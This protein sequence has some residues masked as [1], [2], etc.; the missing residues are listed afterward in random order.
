MSSLNNDDIV[1]GS[2]GKGQM[3]KYSTGKSFKVLSD[4][5]SSSVYSAY[6]SKDGQYFATT[7]SD[8]TAIV[9]DKDGIKL[10]VLRGHTDS[11]F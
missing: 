8:R 2:D 1:F 4:H 5:T 7:S 9:Y 10:H 6:Y 3:Y 11:I